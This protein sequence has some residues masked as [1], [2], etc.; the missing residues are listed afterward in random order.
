M[1]TIHPD[2]LHTYPPWMMQNL[3]G[4]FCG[5]CD[6]FDDAGYENLDSDLWWLRTGYC[7]SW[8]RDTQACG[9][10]HHGIP[11]GYYNDRQVME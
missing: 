11:K 3:L 5:E 6:N 2:E 4:P 1:I 10:C 8:R 7:K 9:F